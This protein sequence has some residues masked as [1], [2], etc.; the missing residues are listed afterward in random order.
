MSGLGRGARFGRLSLRLS[1]WGC[2]NRPFYHI[3]VQKRNHPNRRYI[4][5]IEQVGSYDPTVNAHNEKLC[6]LNL[7]RIQHYLAGGI[8]VS[9]PVAQ[10]LGLA[11]LLPLHPETY[12]AAW[13]NR[14]SLVD[15]NY[16]RMHIPEKIREE[17]I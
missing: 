15:S 12:I 5:N 14:K 11:G 17:K 16:R 13:R 8:H 2:T 4:D 10:L 3:V 1:V 7:E 9:R 6:A